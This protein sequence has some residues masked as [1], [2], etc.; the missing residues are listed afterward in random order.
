MR[1]SLLLLVGPLAW[2]AACT[3][4]AE[5][6]AILPTEKIIVDTK[7]GPRTFTVEIAA[8]PKSQQRG[9]MFR[10]EM[11]AD[12]GMLFDFHEPQP[13]SFWMENTIL[14]LDMLFVRQNGTIANIRENAVPFSRDNIPSDGNVQLV[15]EINGG[16]SKSL[17]IAAGSTVH[18]PELHNMPPA[19]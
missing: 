6:L 3:A 14:P 17:G 5:S 4:Q 10:K 11:D 13:V 16:L 2:L 19:K 8:D 12:A 7:T 1:P 9:L 15:I 18:A